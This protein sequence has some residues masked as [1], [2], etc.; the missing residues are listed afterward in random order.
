M[1][2]RLFIA[3]SFHRHYL[4]G[5]TGKV[6]RQLPVVQETFDSLEGLFGLTRKTLQLSMMLLSSVDRGWRDSLIIP[7]DQTLLSASKTA[8]AFP[9]PSSP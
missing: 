3:P 8:R 9:S 4:C 1:T 7:R 6:K 2:T 5:G